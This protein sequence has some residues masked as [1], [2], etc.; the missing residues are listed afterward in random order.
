MITNIATHRLPTYL[1]PLRLVDDASARLTSI[2][3]WPNSSILFSE[4]GALAVESAIKLAFT[5]PSHEKNAQ[6]VV[7]VLN[8][9]FHGIFG[10]SS[11]ASDPQL[12]KHRCP[13]LDGNNTS[14]GELLFV[15]V[16][17]D[18]PD[19]NPTDLL[20]HIINKNVI[21][22]LEPIR[23]TGGDLPL[24]SNALN[25][26][27]ETLKIHS[28]SFLLVYD[29]I[30]SGFY[31]TSKIWGYQSL[32]LVNP[33]LIVF[34]KRSQVYGVMADFSFDPLQFSSVKTTFNGQLI[35]FYRFN[36]L[37]DFYQNCSVL[38]YNSRLENIYRVFCSKYTSF[39]ATA[40]GS[41]WCLDM[42]DNNTRDSLVSYLEDNN[43][44][45]N[46]TV[47]SSI[48]LR[49]SPFISTSDLDNLFS[50]LSR[51]LDSL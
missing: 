14:Y 35:D 32:C 7:I 34:G 12:T 20:T 8:H 38:S 11:I 31:S 28:K 41:L 36:L 10:I 3:P 51:F 48:R 26:F 22:L 23:C 18:L 33:D 16:N 44:L 2:A 30:Q 5:H 37:F 27:V 17:L 4:S 25:I 49:P 9:A 45:V 21:F 43:I 50:V 1:Y 42:F 13:L 15:R 47:S 40:F 19:F 29:E 46:P 24:D 6:T 39:S